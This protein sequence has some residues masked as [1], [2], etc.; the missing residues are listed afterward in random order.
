MS[1]KNQPMFHE[2]LNDAKPI[3]KTIGVLLILVVIYTIYSKYFGE[4]N[5]MTRCMNEMTK[6]IKQECKEKVESGLF[7]SELKCNHD[8]RQ[9]T[10]LMCKNLTKD[11]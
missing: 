4:L 5:P 11:I 2:I 6:N 1:N 10:K 3:L 7:S 9:M 8:T